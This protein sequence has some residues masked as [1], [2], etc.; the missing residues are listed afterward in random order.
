MEYGLLS[1]LNHEKDALIVNFLSILDAEAQI[2]FEGFFSL[3]KKFT[4]K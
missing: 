2:I 3:M 1:N 4:V